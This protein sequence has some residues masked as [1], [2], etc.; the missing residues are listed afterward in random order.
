MM[1]GDGKRQ[2]R[3]KR[4]HVGGHP[5]FI[6][7]HT[8]YGNVRGICGGGHVTVSG[9]KSRNI[10]FAKAEKRDQRCLFEVHMK[11][12]GYSLSP[13][14]VYFYVQKGPQLIGISLGKFTLN[15]GSGEFKQKHP[16]SL[17]QAYLALFERILVPVSQRYF[18]VKRK[19][20][21]PVL[22]K[23]VLL[24]G[25]RSPPLRAFQVRDPGGLASAL[26]F[27]SGKFSG[28]DSIFRR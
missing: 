28:N 3:T 4:R 21:P 19:F 15:R 17:S 12:T 11:N 7:Y 25:K 6:L 20:P 2:V 8:F 16:L 1:S 18:A 26:A 27:H 23:Y 13:V 5:G 10:G 22:Q 24:Q 9:I 14:Q